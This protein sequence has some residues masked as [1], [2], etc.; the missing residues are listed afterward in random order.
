MKLT[1][2][3]R[4]AITAML[5]L[6]MHDG[7]DMVALSDI[8]RRQGISQSY[9][10]QLFTK[11]RRSGLVT[12]AR[13]PGG[14]YRLAREAGAI[15]LVDIVQAINEN[16]DTTLCGGKKNCRDGETCL[17]HSLW[18]ELGEH[19]LKYLSTVSLA[20]LAARP[21]VIEVAANQERKYENRSKARVSLP[22]RNV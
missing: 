22:Q 2:K 6:A 11:L 17:T 16:I 3:G 7:S 12:S 8:S 14:G 20:E 13:G 10:E 15:S 18:Q 19:I 9:L 4:Y 5:D 1:T 21:H